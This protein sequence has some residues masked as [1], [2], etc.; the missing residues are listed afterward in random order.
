M[1]AEFNFQDYVTAEFISLFQKSQPSF[2]K[3]AGCRD[4][5]FQTF[6]PGRGKSKQIRYAITICEKCPV[7]FECLEY[8]M[9][10]NIEYGVWG[11]STPEERQDWKTS[12]VTMEEL[13]SNLNLK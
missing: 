9:K 6:F 7:R 8:A 2:Y 12:L 13:W 3:E 11:G 10:E 5:G 4:L 1:T